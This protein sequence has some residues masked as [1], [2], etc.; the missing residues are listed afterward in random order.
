METRI[1]F[2]KA[3]LT[4]LPVPAAGQRFTF[5]DIKQPG[6]QLRVTANN[7]KTFAVF[8]RVAGG[9]PERVSIGRFPEVTVEQARSRAREVVNQLATGVSLSATKKAKAAEKAQ[10]PTVETLREALERYVTTATRLS[11]DKPLKQRTVDDYRA[12]IKAPVTKRTGRVTKA[13]ELRPLADRLLTDITRDEIVGLY[14]ANK[15][16][17]GKRR[18]DYAAVVLRAV[19]NF[20][21]VPVPEHTFKSK[22]NR[23]GIGI[24]QSDPAGEAI[25]PE[26]RGRWWAFLNELPDSDNVNFVRFIAL[27]GCRPNEPEKLTIADI[28]FIQQSAT[29]PDT[30]NRLPHMIC[31]SSQAWHIVEKQ[32]AGKGK[33]D[34]LFNTRDVWKTVKDIREKTGI[35]FHCKMLRSTFASIADDEE[36]AISPSTI[37]R[38]LNHKQKDAEDI[39]D[40]RYIIKTGQQMRRA[41]QKIADHWDQQAS[42]AKADT[43]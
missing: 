37:K 41:W 10:A 2:T 16:A 19:F 27:T 39:T 11:D 3:A 15:A 23:D 7:V 6:L 33:D 20:A 35:R 38:L 22:T 13:G 42:L 12:M 43:P 36:V 5:H 40:A 1:N 9:S 30:K 29:V 8:K 26:D 14:A 31:F 24:S 4:N 18:A 28:D 21:R 34:L 32:A 25:A 17:H